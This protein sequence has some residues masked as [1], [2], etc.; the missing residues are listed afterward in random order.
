MRPD[1]KKTITQLGIEYRL[2]TQFTSFVAVEERVVTTGGKPRRIDVP[3]EVPKG[4]QRMMDQEPSSQATPVGL[5]NATLG[6]AGIARKSMRA[7]ANG[8][9]ILPTPPNFPPAVSGISVNGAATKDADVPGPTAVVV[10]QNNELAEKLHRSVFALVNKLKN[11]EALSADESSLI[12][13]GRVEVQVW[14]TVKSDDVLAQLK[15]LG[16]EVVSDTKSSK[17]IIGTLPVE[18]LEAL[19]KLKAVK[20]IAP[21]K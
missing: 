8:G 21:R 7:R 12:R 11:K 1:L 14:L 6:G 10:P 4:V 9:Y 3:V 19:A 20:Y 5:A 16:F 17:V 18:K 2:M 15:E 13:D